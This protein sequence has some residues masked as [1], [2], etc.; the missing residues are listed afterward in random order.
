MTDPVFGSLE[1]TELL[2]CYG[3]WQGICRAD[4]GGR[5]CEV[6]VRIQRS[7]EDGGIT[8]RQRE[9]WQRFL[10]AWPEI[11][12]KLIQALIRYYNETER[13]AWGPEDPEEF[14]KWWPEIETAGALLQA[15][16]WEAAVIPWDYVMTDVKKGRCVYLLFSRAWGGED[17]D[18]NGIGVCLCN[19]EVDEIGYK[20][21][22]E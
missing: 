4:F 2:G 18:D 12:P 8:E 16:T 1:E 14:A 17:W 20:D 11:Q 21:I 22:A 19:E 9:A 10:E 5:P 15:V 13:F 6:E 7:E 3:G